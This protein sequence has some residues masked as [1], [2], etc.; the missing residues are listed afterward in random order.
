MK[1]NIKSAVYEQIKW[2][3]DIAIEQLE[4]IGAS[5]GMNMDGFKKIVHCKE[6]RNSDGVIY[7]NGDEYYRCKTGR[8]HSANW[9]CADGLRKEGI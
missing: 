6:C 4:S 3:R 5:L 8:C 2:E 9:F 1:Q 7:H